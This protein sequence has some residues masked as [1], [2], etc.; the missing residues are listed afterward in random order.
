VEKL[1]TEISA[2]QTEIAK[3]KP[4]VTTDI[5]KRISGWMQEIEGLGVHKS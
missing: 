2:L 1:Q 3:D 4:S 5:E